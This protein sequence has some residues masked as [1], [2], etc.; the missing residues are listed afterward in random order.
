M[1]NTVTS[2]YPVVRDTA[3]GVLE[4]EPGSGMR[5]QQHL[6][7][8]LCSP[9]PQ[10]GQQTLS[11]PLQGKLQFFGG[12]TWGHTTTETLSSPTSLSLLYSEVWRALRHLWKTEARVGKMSSE[13]RL[14]GICDSLSW[15]LSPTLRCHLQKKRGQW[16]Q[17]SNMDAPAS[18]YL[19]GPHPGSLPRLI[20]LLPP[21]PVATLLCQDI[22]RNM[23]S[24]RPSLSISGP[25]RRPSPGVGNFSSGPQGQQCRL[26]RDLLFARLLGKIRLSKP[27]AGCGARDHRP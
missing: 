15:N 10:G 13:P 16:T 6:C 20:H 17:W 21:S 11:L 25:R 24:A 3:A 27:K 26:R 9:G 7:F 12:V 19:Q 8:L 1:E 2:Q 22:G 18:S 23:D 14:P 4:W 5:S